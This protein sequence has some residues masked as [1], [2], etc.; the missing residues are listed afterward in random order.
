MAEMPCVDERTAGDVYDK[1][2]ASDFGPPT[3]R[4]PESRWRPCLLSRCFSLDQFI[5]GKLMLPLLCVIP[6]V[7]IG[8]N[9]ILGE[10]IK[11]FNPAYE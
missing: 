5:A 8:S 1:Y 9:L 10:A 11:L 6:I 4:P 3:L 7:D 2:L